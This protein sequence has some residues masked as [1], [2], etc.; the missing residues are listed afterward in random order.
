MFRRD[1]TVVV[2]G[3]G[4][5]GNSAWVGDRTAGVLIDC[6][7]S[8]LQVMKRLAAV[9]MEHAPIDGVLVT[10]EHADH[11]GGARV[12]CDRLRK[13]SGRPIPFYM[14]T[15]TLRGSNPKSRPDA[16]EEIVPGEGFHIRH[17]S[18]DPFSVPHDVRDPVAFRVGVDGTWAGVV[19]DLGRPTALVR[20]KLASLSVAVL[21]FNH[22]RERLRD[23]PYPWHLKQRIRSAHGHL[24]ND[25]AASMLQDALQGGTP[26]QHIVLAHLSAENNTP[27]LARRSCVEVLAAHE[28]EDRVGVSVAEQARPLPPITVAT[29]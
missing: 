1:L 24:A 15:G 7:L 27:D 29:A 6:G 3:S 23:G 11:I 4:S 19:T 21:E 17:L 26:L 13:R 14:T 20:R 5:K 12:L 9:G 18:I 8:T 22:D 16:V 2:L 10:H 25:E 28:L